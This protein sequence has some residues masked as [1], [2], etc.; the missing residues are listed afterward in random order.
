M[1]STIPTITLLTSVDPTHASGL[2]TALSSATHA[3]ATATEDGDLYQYS[4]S[5]AAASNSLAIISAQSVMATATGAAKLL[6]SENIMSAATELAQ[7]AYLDNMYRADLNMGANVFFCVIFGLVMLWHFIVGGIFQYW[8]FFCMFGIGSGLDFGGYLARSVSAADES[9]INPFLVQI[10]VLT[11]APAFIMAGI[12]YLLGREIVYLGPRFSWLK[13]RWFSYIYITCDVISL[14]IQAIGGGMAATALAD[15]KDTDSGTHVMVA[16]IAFQ[17]L[18]MSTFIIVGGNFALRSWF[19]ALPE[20][21]FSVSNFLSLFF[22]VGKANE[23]YRHLEPEYNPDFAH[24]RNRKLARFVF[25]AIFTS[26]V[27][28]YIRCIYRLVEL[29][30]GWTGYIIRHEAFLFGLDGAMIFLTCFIFVPFHPGF[31]WGKYHPTLSYKKGNKQPQEDYDQEKLYGDVTNSQNP[32]DGPSH[33]VEKHRG[34]SFSGEANPYDSEAKFYDVETNPYD[35]KTNPYD[36]GANPYGGEA[37]PY[38]GEANLNLSNGEADQN[39]EHH[40]FKGDSLPTAA[41]NLQGESG[42]YGLPVDSPERLTQ[43]RDFTSPKEG[44]GAL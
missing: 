30:E 24:V 33:E 16:G 42:H 41:E 39:N 10:I 34:D 43:P 14:V 19:R 5:V 26:T 3:L 18:T 8:Y 31:L 38:D 12:Y 7:I 1:A 37:N 23:L 27:M 36:D 40:V 21:K 9:A 4:K 15:N 29:A 2:Y 20:V 11:I 13:P 6:A 25:P 44:H 35:G 28:V 22:N 17:V 32:S